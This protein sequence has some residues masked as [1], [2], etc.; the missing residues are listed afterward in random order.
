MIGPKNLKLPHKKKRVRIV[1]KLYCATEVE[2]QTPAL[3]CQFI[4]MRCIK[5]IFDYFL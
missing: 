2:V 5:V 4:L 1:Y 3:S